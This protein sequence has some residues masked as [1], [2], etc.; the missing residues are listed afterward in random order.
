[1]TISGNLTINGTL[2]DNIDT[3][4]NNPEAMLIGRSRGYAYLIDRDKAVNEDGKAI[5]ANY[6]LELDLDDDDYIIQ[7]KIIIDFTAEDMEAYA[8]TR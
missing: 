4:W 3:L 2:M 5:Y 7:R 8:R 1:M 6:T